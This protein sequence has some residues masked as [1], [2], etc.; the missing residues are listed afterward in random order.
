M[1]QPAKLEL[2]VNNPWLHLTLNTRRYVGM[3][4]PRA[5][6]LYS[7]HCGSETWLRPGRLGLGLVKMESGSSM[8]V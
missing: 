7:L 1:C 5:D 8:S 6:I 3:N 2:W 4:G